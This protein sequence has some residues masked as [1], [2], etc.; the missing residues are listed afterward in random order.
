[1]QDNCNKMEL[2]D[3]AQ[4]DLIITT[5]CD[6]LMCAGLSYDGMDEVLSK[7]NDCHGKV[8][9]DFILRSTRIP[10]KKYKDCTSRILTDNLLTVQIVLIKTN[11]TI[12][13]KIL[14]VLS[15]ILSMMLIRKMTL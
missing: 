4:L 8:Y 1:M 5:F 2:I 11:P 15:I 3:P 6:S 12:N 10:S 9:N 7:A 14:E 13:R